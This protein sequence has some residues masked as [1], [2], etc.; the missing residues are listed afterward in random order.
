[1]DFI[2]W[3]AVEAR[4]VVGGGLAICQHD[5]C[6]VGAV[7]CGQVEIEAAACWMGFGEVLEAQIMRGDDRSTG[8]DEG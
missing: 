6:S 8:K 3:R 4:Q 5:R 1:M 7:A 2:R